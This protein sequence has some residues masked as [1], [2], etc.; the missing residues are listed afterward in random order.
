MAVRLNL[1]F[2]VHSA[3]NFVQ[4]VLEADPIEWT[5][6]MGWIRL[7]QSIIATWYVSRWPWE[8]GG[9]SGP[10]LIGAIDGQAP[11]QIRA[12]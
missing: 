8:L 1:N 6:L 7:Q 9:I 10:N 3:Y 4:K 11:E 2:S 5:S 12:G